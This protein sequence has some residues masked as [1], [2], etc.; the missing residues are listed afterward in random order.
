MGIWA[1]QCDGV[2]LRPSDIIKITN[3]QWCN[4]GIGM[5]F[6]Q[7]SIC[8]LHSSAITACRQDEIA[9]SEKFAHVLDICFGIGMLGNK[10]LVYVVCLI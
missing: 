2:A 1:Q 6:A 4:Q 8:N 3:S 9:L 10:F 7:H 5:V